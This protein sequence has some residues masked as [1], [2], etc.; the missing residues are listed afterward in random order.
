M[1]DEKANPPELPWA[2]RNA[3]QRSFS[4]KQTVSLLLILDIEL[5]CSFNTSG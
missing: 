5:S 3:L 1:A 2:P 4:V